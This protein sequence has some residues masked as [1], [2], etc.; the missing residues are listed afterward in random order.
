[1]VLFAAWPRGEVLNFE[2][3]RNATV[4]SGLYF[5]RMEAVSVENPNKRFMD[6]KKMILLK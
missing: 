1:V 6:V 3:G 5:Y 2:R 4:A